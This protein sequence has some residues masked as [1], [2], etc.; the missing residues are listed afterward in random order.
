MRMI[1]ICSAGGNFLNLFERLFVIPIAGEAALPHITGQ[2]GDRRMF[3]KEA[4]RDACSLISAGADASELSCRWW[5][6]RCN[7][8]MMSHMR[9]CEQADLAL[10]TCFLATASDAG[11]VEAVL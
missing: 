11:R 9:Q 1:V 7:C 8:R 4:R 3:K 5:L 6:A 2:V 10:P